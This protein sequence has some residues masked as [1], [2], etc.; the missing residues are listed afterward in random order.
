VNKKLLYVGLTTFMAGAVSVGC[1][2]NNT[3]SQGS[4]ADKQPASQSSASTSNQQPASQSTASASGQQGQNAGDKS[5]AEDVVKQY[6]ASQGKMSYKDPSS[7]HA[8]DK[9]LTPDLAKAQKQSQSGRYKFITD[10]KL[11]VK[12][13]NTKVTFLAEKKGAYVFDVT[14]HTVYHSDKQ[15]KDLGSSNIDEEMTVTNNKDT[16]LISSIQNHK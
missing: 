13:E 2:S 15:N 16:L 11:S 14:A 9:Y 5:K 3:A 1:S 4:S 7:F 8:G 10:N 6:M 12:E